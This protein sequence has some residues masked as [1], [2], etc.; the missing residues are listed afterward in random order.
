[1]KKKF[2]R[3]IAAAAVC[4]VLAQ[5]MPAFAVTDAFPQGYVKISSDY[6]AGIPKLNAKYILDD[7]TG[8]ALAWQDNAF[9]GIDPM[10]DEDGTYLQSGAGLY[11][12]WSIARN[13]DET[14]C[15][16]RSADNTALCLAYADGEFSLTDD[17]EKALVLTPMS[18]TAAGTMFFLYSSADEAYLS[19][20]DG[21]L[22]MDKET[23][24]N[25]NLKPLAAQ[26]K[27][28]FYYRD[29]S[30][31]SATEYKTVTS[32]E[33]DKITLPELPEQQ[34]AEPLCWQQLD[35]SD[36]TKVIGEYPAGEVISVDGGEKHTAVFLAKY[37]RQ[38]ATLIP[39]GTGTQKTATVK[40]G[41]KVT[42]ELNQDSPSDF[43]LFAGGT[44][45]V[46]HAEETA[47]GDKALI[48]T[49][50]DAKTY[51][52]ALE[53]ADD[54]EC[55]RITS[56]YDFVNV[57]D[58]I[59]TANIGS[60]FDL[61]L[62]SDI[63]LSGAC[64]ETLGSWEPIGKTDE[65]GTP[66]AEYI[67]LHGNGMTIKN[68]YIDSNSEYQGLFGSV[69]D[70]YVNDLTLRG[71]VKGS[72]NT[73]TIAGTCS[74]LFCTKTLVEADT[75]GTMNAGG[76]AGNVPYLELTNCGF[77]GSVKAN[78]NGGF[79][80]GL[81]EQNTKLSR[82]FAYGTVQGTAVAGCTG[83][84][85]S[86]KY[87]I[88]YVLEDQKLGASEMMF[89]AVSEEAFADGTAAAGLNEGQETEVW[90]QGEKYPVIARGTYQ[91]SVA[92]DEEGGALS[93]PK[94]S[95]SAGDTV[96]FTARANTGYEM[97][98][99]ATTAGGKRSVEIT[100]GEAEN[101]WQFTM[102]AENVNLQI[103]FKKGGDTPYVP[104]DV[105]C[106]GAVDVS[107]AVLLAKLL[108]E[109]QTAVVTQS[110]LRNADVNNSGQPDAED[111]VMILKYIARLITFEIQEH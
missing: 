75:T 110:G 90:A 106:S 27:I 50:T 103:R 18:T 102:P 51:L 21:T 94:T 25:L 86:L 20:Q 13:E 95:Y 60:A 63:D 55:I 56:L 71:T 17:P 78:Q 35:I 43:L 80:V 32:W 11:F 85:N 61:L 8:K 97:M 33:G 14:G 28:L 49:V 83:K 6:T 96:T 16:L 15:L 109:D 23:P 36:M 42:V 5:G 10:T 91:L 81:S 45:T 67:S 76:F 59:N 53:T 111:T 72:A 47:A 107:D 46:V 34:G 52:C 31:T 99:T 9:T 4:A 104:G 88:L 64:S 87:D 48:V 2:M 3:F 92:F 101:T 41:Q 19:W 65:A 29:G 39:I 93:I 58:M 37:E 22:S 38:E 62:K 70:L 79:F 1:M 7:G 66:T 40:S 77:A 84:F 73:G 57:R 69:G 89:Q 54:A 74:R 82:C 108:A 68:L 12:T 44:G 100:P 26:N 105:D 24:Q 98:I 30:S